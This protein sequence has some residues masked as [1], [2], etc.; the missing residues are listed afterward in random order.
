MI[1]QVAFILLIFDE[2]RSM[3]LDEQQ[4]LLNV[5]QLLGNVL[6]TF[7]IGSLFV[8]LFLHVVLIVCLDRCDT[9]LLFLLFLLYG[10]RL[11]FLFVCQIVL[12]SAPFLFQSVQFLRFFFIQVVQFRLYLFKLGVGL[13]FLIFQLMHFPFSLCFGFFLPVFQVEHVLLI[14]LLQLSQFI[15]LYR[16]YIL[17]LFNLRLIFVFQRFFQLFLGYLQTSDFGSNLF[18]TVC[19]GF[20]FLLII[21]D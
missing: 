2:Q 18:Q 15:L 1:D 4:F 13:C 8:K 17:L 20:L 19:S 21:V 12:K 6:Q 5:L 16:D 7:C 9:F 11:F 10:V 3:V 14:L